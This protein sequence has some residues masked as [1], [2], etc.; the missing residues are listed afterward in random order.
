MINPSRHLIIKHLRDV[1]IG[2]AETVYRAPMGAKVIIITPDTEIT[3]TTARLAAYRYGMKV[4]VKRA[5]IITEDDEFL[6][7]VVVTIIKKGRPI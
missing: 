6:K 2:T 3:R 1:S 4:K 7:A 5:R